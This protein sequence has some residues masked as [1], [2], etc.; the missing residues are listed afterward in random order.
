MIKTILTN[1]LCRYGHIKPLNGLQKEKFG[2]LDFRATQSQS[3]RKCVC[4]KNGQR[5][6]TLSFDSLR[7]FRDM[8]DSSNEKQHKT[9]THHNK[10]VRVFRRK[11]TQLTIK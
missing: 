4:V 8:V 7:S 3:W 9:G 1:D 11:K 2:A 5:H 10:F 6:H